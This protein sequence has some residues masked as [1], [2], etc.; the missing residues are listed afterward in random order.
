MLDLSSLRNWIPAADRQHVATI[1]AHTGGEP[2]RVVASGAPAVVGAS[3]LEK[4]RFAQKHHD[5]LRRALMWETPQP[6]TASSPEI[7]HLPTSQPEPRAKCKQV[8]YLAPDAFFQISLVTAEYIVGDN[9]TRSQGGNT[10]QTGEITIGFP[11]KSP[12]IP[13]RATSDGSLAINPYLPSICSRF[14][15]TLIFV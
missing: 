5:A 8:G 13:S 12:L 11:L 2:F 9:L 15:S 10:C 3:M 6:V 1:D 7:I 4:R 14:S